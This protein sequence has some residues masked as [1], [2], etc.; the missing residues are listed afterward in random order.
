MFRNLLFCIC[1]STFIF[2]FYSKPL[3]AQWNYS[4]LMNRLAQEKSKV[5]SHQ[6]TIHQIPVRGK[7]FENC[8]WIHEYSSSGGHDVLAVL[9]R[10][11]TSQDVYFWSVNG[12]SDRYRIS[13]TYR[14]EEKSSGFISAREKTSL[15]LPRSIKFLDW[16]TAGLGFCGDVGSSFETISGNIAGWDK[17]EV[18]RKFKQDAKSLIVEEDDIRI[19]VESDDGMRI[20]RFLNGIPVPDDETTKDPYLSEWKVIYKKHGKLKLPSEA[21]LRCHDAMVKYEFIWDSVNEPL[22]LGAATVQR[23]VKQIPGAKSRDQKGPLR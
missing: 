16:K 23:F 5:V 2:L 8:T 20:I 11:L 7:M 3:S 14:K 19:E 13:G 12:V 9:N 21:T 1:C 15:D 18:E 10:E 22:E 4:E 6:L 17:V